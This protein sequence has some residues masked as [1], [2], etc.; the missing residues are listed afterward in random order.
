MDQ[1]K[2]IRFVPSRFLESFIAVAR[3]LIFRPRQ[4]FE[5]LR[6]SGSLF[7][8]LTFLSLCLFLSRLI[9]ANALGANLPLF[10]GLFVSWI[11]SAVLGSMCLHAVLVSPLFNARLPYE[12]TLSII[13]YAC[14]VE[15]VA[16]I[17]LLGVIAKFYGLFFMYIGFKAIHQLPARRAAFA[18]FLAVLLTNIIRLMMLRLLAPEWL[19]SLIQAIESSG[20]SA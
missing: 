17:P 9:V 15:L 6:P 3:E 1:P 18:V 11:V 10:I 16:W 12:A 2:T 7:G 5:Q 4:F 8:P 19:D 20:I 14:I 13:A